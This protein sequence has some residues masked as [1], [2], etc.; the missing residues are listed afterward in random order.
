MGDVREKDTAVAAQEPLERAG[1]HSVFLGDGDA[2]GSGE[3]FGQIGNDHDLLLFQGVLS[4]DTLHG[5]Y[6]LWISTN[7]HFSNF[8]PFSLLS[9]T[10]I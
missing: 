2:L 4:H 7:N 3:P 5:N 9:N 8:L 1:Q 10:C 6:C